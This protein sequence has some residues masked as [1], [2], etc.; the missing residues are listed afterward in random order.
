MAGGGGAAGCG[1]RR[2]TPMDGLISVWCGG[3]SLEYRK[4]SD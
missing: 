4:E 3:D 1:Y 2:I